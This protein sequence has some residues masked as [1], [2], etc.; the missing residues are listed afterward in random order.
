[1]CTTY[2]LR[3]QCQVQVRNL[4]MSLTMVAM[5]YCLWMCPPPMMLSTPEIHSLLQQALPSSLTGRTTFW[6]TQVCVYVCA[7]MRACVWIFV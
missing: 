4:L 3:L 5:K 6:Q 7:R 2:L 1:M